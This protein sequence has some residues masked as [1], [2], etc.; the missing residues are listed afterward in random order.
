[1]QY[2]NFLSN[3][4]HLPTVWYRIIGM[5]VH[6]IEQWA[7]FVKYHAC[8]DVNARGIYTKDC[9]KFR[10]RNVE[11]HLEFDKILKNVF[12]ENKSLWLFTMIIILLKCS[13]QTEN[14]KCLKQ[15][16]RLLNDQSTMFSQR[17]DEYSY[18]NN[19]K[20][21]NDNSSEWYI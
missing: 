21:I 7:H 16:N 4:C 15:L 3:V 12:K 5:P 10:N 19:I 20:K 1:M 6:L 17:S 8:I 13:K 18:Y 11:I 2:Q 9:W 14:V